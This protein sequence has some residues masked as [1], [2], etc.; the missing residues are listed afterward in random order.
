MMGIFGKQIQ[1]AFILYPFFHQIVQR[2]DA[3]L[4][5]FQTISSNDWGPVTRD[6]TESHSAFACVR[7][8]VTINRKHRQ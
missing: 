7:T 1:H 4:E 5:F 8:W 6:E 2:Q 3:P